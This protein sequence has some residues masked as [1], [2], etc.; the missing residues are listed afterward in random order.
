MAEWLTGSE[1]AFLSDLCPQ[2]C[3]PP[4]LMPI[5]GYFPVLVK[6]IGLFLDYSSPVYVLPDYVMYL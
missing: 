1:K 4:S 6:F 2:S 5:F 3:V